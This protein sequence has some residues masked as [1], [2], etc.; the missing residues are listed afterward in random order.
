M[1]Q[2]LSHLIGD[3]LSALLFLFIYLAT[4]NITAANL[5]AVS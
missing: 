3:L 2:A 4:G 1:K 5:R